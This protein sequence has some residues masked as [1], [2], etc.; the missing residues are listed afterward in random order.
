M[1]KIQYSSKDEVM[2][3]N[4]VNHFEDMIKPINLL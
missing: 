3:F 1:D 2:V 4:L